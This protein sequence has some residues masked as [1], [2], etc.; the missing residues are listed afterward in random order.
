MRRAWLLA[1]VT[2]AVIVGWGVLFDV[3]QHAGLLTGLYWSVTTATTVGYGDIT[4]RG[5]SGRLLAIGTMLTAIPLLA[6]TFSE[7]HLNRIRGNVD[8]RLDDLQGR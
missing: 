3:T 2:A 4:P 5:D 8:A 7:I 1:A 6:A